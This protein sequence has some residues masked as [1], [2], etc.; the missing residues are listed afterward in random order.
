MSELASYSIQAIFFALVAVVVVSRS[1]KTDLY[2]FA[3]ISIWLIGVIAIYAR[4]GEDQVLF[5]SNDQQFHRQVLEYYI[6]E[7]GLHL[8]A[9]IGLR[10]LLTVPVYLISLLGFNA[11]LVIKLFQLMSLLEMYRTSKRYLV[12][13]QIAVKPWHIVLFAGPIMVFMSLLALRDLLLALFVIKFVFETSSKQKTLGLLFAFLLR[14]HLGVAL[15]VGA[16]IAYFYIQLKPRFQLLNLCVIS[17]C[18]YVFGSVTYWFGSFIQRGTEIKPPE[19]LFT[20]LKFTRLL[21]NFFGLQFLTLRGGD[22]TVVALPNLVLLVSRLI[23]LDT[24]LIPMLFLY[25]LFAHV[26]FLSYQ[27]VSIFLSFVFFYGIVS[28]TTF[29]STRQNIP[30]LACMG[31]LAVADIEHFRKIKAKVAPKLLMATR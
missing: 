25:A 18:T 12:R 20:Q 29:N 28:Q 9:A 16:L 22:D 21:A 1:K 10:Y 13:S 3:L 30:F 26:K 27:K 24:F 8:N 19:N 2:Q 15:M 23:F 5:Y 6:P 4:Y 31:L 17:L 7:E 11:M 14:P